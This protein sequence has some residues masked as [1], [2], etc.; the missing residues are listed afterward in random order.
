[1]GTEAV[2][3]LHG[4]AHG[5]EAVGR[6]PDGR[7]VFVAH[8]LPGETV[9]VRITEQ[10][11]RWSRGVLVEVVTPSQ[12]RVEPPCPY[13]GPGRCGGCRLQHIAPPRRREL[14]R[15]VV[16]DQ[17]ERLGG[18]PEPPV[19]AVVPAG[20]YGYRTRA[21]FAVTGDGHLAFRRH[22]SHDL[23]TVDRCLLLDEP[24]QALREAAGDDW[25]GH[26][27]VEVRTGVEGGT[28]IAD[29][30]GRRGDA[31]VERVGGFDFRVGAGS[32]FQSNREGAG[33][34][35]RLVR[36]AAA[37]TKGDTALDLY[38]GVGLFA[39]GLAADGAAV[40][41]VEGNRS[42]AA[43][44]EHN[45]AGLATVL[46]RPVD[47]ALRRFVDRG[48]RFTVVVADP[49]R[50]GAGRDVITAAAAVAQRTVVVVA[51]D[52]AA[53]GRDTATLRDAGWDLARA[54][55]VDQFAQT[56]HVEVVATFR[57]ALP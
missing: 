31:L 1:M 16:S 43:D 35:L 52:P 19:A 56:G 46:H 2:V 51:C 8:A 26:A 4:F 7:V 9:R 27:E 44:A 10:R 41:A 21:R 22:G 5:G 48:E 55:P 3:A 28:V 49:P 14:L 15:Q 42:S 37:V 45:L 11:K 38:A 23:I 57:P 30:P 18:V 6:M 32:F 47:R 39:R 17:L 13:F 36:E 20:E 34:L 53:L 29:P 12:D 40:T 24:T 25:A 50:D 54:V 33:H